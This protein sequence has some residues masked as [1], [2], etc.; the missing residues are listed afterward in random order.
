MGKKCEEINEWVEEEVSK[1]VEEWEE[2]REEKCK[3][4]KWYD[5]RRWLCWIVVT[6][7]K[8]I[9]WIVVKVGKWVVRIVC[10]VITSALEGLLHVFRGLVTFFR[11]LFNL[12][13][14]MMLDGLTEAITGFLGLAGLIL[15]IIIFIGLGPLGL[16]L[17]GALIVLDIADYIISEI[18]DYRLREYVKGL[19][20]A[21]YGSEGE[22]YDAMA[23]ALG[24]EHGAF[25]YH[26]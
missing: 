15:L 1:P 7:V 14:R 9:R 8:V 6:L 24:L 2:R 25:G 16:I 5:P 23:D 21:K 11:G 4:R 12:D 10:R 19:V 17:L 13:W 18:N 3:K 20:K 26:G 22:T